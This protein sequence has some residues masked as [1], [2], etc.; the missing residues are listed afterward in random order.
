MGH[1]QIALGVASPTAPSLAQLSASAGM[2]P[3]LSR[4]GEVASPT[5]NQELMAAA[6]ED[7]SLNSLDSRALGVAQ[8]T[9][10]RGPYVNPL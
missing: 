2:K 3:I 5:A 6:S 8:G 1:H 7:L 4:F 10:G 9:R